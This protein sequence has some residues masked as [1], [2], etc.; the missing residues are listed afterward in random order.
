MFMYS[1][2]R[3]SVFQET[4]S[5]W[6]INSSTIFFW[7][8]MLYQI[9]LN[10]E[11]G[12]LALEYSSS[13]LTSWHSWWY[14]LSVQE[15]QETQVRSL[16]Q[17]DPLE[18]EMAMHSSTRAWK[19]PWTDESGGLQS[20]GLQRVGHDWSNWAHLMIIYL[21]RPMGISTD[22]RGCVCVRVRARARARTCASTLAC[23]KKNAYPQPMMLAQKWP[24]SGASL[25]V[26]WFRLCTSTAGAADSIPGWKIKILH[27]V[28]CGQIN[29]Q[30]NKTYHIL[31][32]LRNKL[33]SAAVETYAQNR[34]LPAI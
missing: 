1:A 8:S 18:E 31:T 33:P 24:H 3:S 32:L 4:V 21:K 9:S 17:E 27:A 23:Q 26:Q 12:L 15:M 29:K 34:H 25:E 2:G 19:I 28:W 13:R 22:F 10:P 11:A 7:K 30:I 6:D 16:G 14:C 5:F 20:M